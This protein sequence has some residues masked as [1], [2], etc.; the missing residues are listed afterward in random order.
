MELPTPDNRVQRPSHVASEL[1]PLSEREFPAVRQDP[2]H[3]AVVRRNAVSPFP[4]MGIQTLITPSEAAELAVQ[5]LRPRKGGSQRIA[6]RVAL[7]DHEL[8]GVIRRVRA[9]A[10][11]AY[12]GSVPDRLHQRPPGS[13]VRVRAGGSGVHVVVPPQLPPGAADVAEGYLPVLGELVLEEEVPRVD[14]LRGVVV[15]PVP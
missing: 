1:A 9:V 14:I 6:L 2:D 4:V 15:G 10:A 8:Q 12:A 11:V 7:L 3:G 5:C 13:L